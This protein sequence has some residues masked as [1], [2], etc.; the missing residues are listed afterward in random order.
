MSRNDLDLLAFLPCPPKVPEKYL[1]ESVK[2]DIIKKKKLKEKKKRGPTG[3]AL[4]R[5]HMAFA[6]IDDSEKSEYTSP[7]HRLVTPTQC[8]SRENTPFLKA[9][10]LNRNVLMR[11]NMQTE[12][13]ITTLPLLLNS[14]T[15]AIY[16]DK[17]DFC[18]FNCC[19]KYDTRP[20]GI[21]E[22]IHIVTKSYRCVGYYCSFECA[23][24]DVRNCKSSK[25]RMTAGSHLLS[26]RKALYGV[27]YTE[28][29]IAA[30]DR[31]VLKMFGGHMDIDE[32]RK[33]NYE[34]IVCVE[35]VRM[36][37]V[38]LNVYSLKHGQKNTM[39]GPKRKQKPRIKI[40]GK[41]T[42]Q[43][44]KKRMRR[45]VGSTKSATNTSIMLQN[46]KRKNKFKMNIKAVNEFKL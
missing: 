6:F 4:K 39:L 14:K 3:C 22:K 7:I 20:I 44:K 5:S 13:K 21:P 36:I 9:D 23:M 24:A 16:P 12:Y 15:S 19:H 25:T 17:V 11:L 33:N 45:I 28:P 35:G 41:D 26:L 43:K 27:P 18:C 34:S 38:G 40:D 46:I 42:I 1:H 8:E 10:L 30:P 29:L 32:Y 2:D 37:P 31:R